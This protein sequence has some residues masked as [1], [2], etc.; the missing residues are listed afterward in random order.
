[1]SDDIKPPEIVFNAQLE[2]ANEDH[3]DSADPTGFMTNEQILSNFRSMNQW[4]KDERARFQI[5][6]DQYERLANSYITMQ[7]DMDIMRANYG[8][9]LVKTMG[10]G[11]TVE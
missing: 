7:S 9:L 2:R 11:S 5:L 8:A 3:P 6:H 10:H 1:M 4:M